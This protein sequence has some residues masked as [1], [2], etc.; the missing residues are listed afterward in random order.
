MPS[1]GNVGSDESN[2]A[3]RESAER[4][5]ITNAAHEIQSPL[6]AILSAVEVLQAGAKD[7]PER[8]IFL[9]HI[10]QASLRLARLARALLVL[11]RAESD[12]EVPR[13]ELVALQPLLTDVAAGLAPL[14]GV[15]TEISC[16]PDAAVVTNRELLEQVVQNIAANAAKYTASGKILLA[17][18]VSNGDAEITVRDT[19]QGIP[20]SEQRRVFD[21]FYRGQEASDR[22]SGLGLAIVRAAMRVLDGEVELE[23]AAGEGTTVRIRLPQ[24]ASLVEP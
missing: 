19:G 24:G 16:H 21:R 1:P 2:R 5:F 18:E 9:N 3:R 22:G 14:E 8:D 7:T 4:E 10:Q 17:A 20:T 13:T 11:A 12:A 23:S 15:A 6:T